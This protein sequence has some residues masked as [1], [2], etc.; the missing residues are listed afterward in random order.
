MTVETDD[1]EEEEEEGMLF[2]EL[3][4]VQGTRTRGF[5]IFPER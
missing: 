4:L 2:E 1:P 3:S 5:V